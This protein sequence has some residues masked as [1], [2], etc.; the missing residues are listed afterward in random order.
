[1]IAAALLG[2]LQDPPA[3]EEHAPSIRDFF[4]E[5]FSHTHQSVARKNLFIQVSCSTIEIAMMLASFVLAFHAIHIPVEA[6]WGTAA[7]ILA[8]SAAVAMALP[9]S[10]GAG[11]GAAITFVFALLHFSTEQALAYAILWWFLSQVPALITG[12]PSFF[13]LKRNPDQEAKLSG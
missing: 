1:M 9:P 4:R 8:F 12:I 6:P 10:Y 7:I 13:L 5:C 2:R 11:P 3:E